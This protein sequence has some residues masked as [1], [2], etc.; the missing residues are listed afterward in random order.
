VQGSHFH[1][2]NGKKGFL[3]TKDIL[4]LFRGSQLSVHEFRPLTIITCIISMFDNFISY[5]Y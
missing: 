2:N 1:I 5:Q 4:R 3:K